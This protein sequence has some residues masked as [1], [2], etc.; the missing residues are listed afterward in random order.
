[1]PIASQAGHVALQSTHIQSTHRWCTASPALL[2]CQRSR[3]EFWWCRPG[4]RSDV[5]L[6]KLFTWVHLVLVHHPPRGEHIDLIQEQITMW[7]QVTS[8]FPTAPFIHFITVKPLSYEASFLNTAP[9]GLLC[10]RCTS[11]PIHVCKASSPE[12]LKC[13]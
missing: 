11:K 3:C 7:L 10:H 8:S 6:K 13:E 2:T 12:R 5:D 1:M 4:C 9:E